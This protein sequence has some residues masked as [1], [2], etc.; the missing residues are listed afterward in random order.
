MRDVTAPSLSFPDTDDSAETLGEN[1]GRMPLARPKKSRNGRTLNF[2]ICEATV[3]VVFLAS[4]AMSVRAHL[5]ADPANAIFTGLTIA[6]AFAVAVIP[7]VFFG[8]TRLR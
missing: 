7:V 2:V 4:G 1:S 6:A 3:L 5:A 8:P